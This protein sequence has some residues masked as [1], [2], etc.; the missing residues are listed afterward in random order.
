[1]MSL[2]CPKCHGEMRQYER[3]GVVIDQCSECRGIFLDRGELEKLFEAEANW[4][5]QQ[6][7]PAP[8]QPS[9]PGGY[10]PPPP[11]QQ[12]PGYGTVPPPP[13]PAHGYPPAPA[14]AYGGHGQ[15]YGYHGHYRRKRHKGFLGD[16]LG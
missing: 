2:T 5:R 11:P 9:Q 12:Q 16:L 1:M 15:H 4:N 10:P 3:S 6:A 8:A 7:A 14:P 13:P